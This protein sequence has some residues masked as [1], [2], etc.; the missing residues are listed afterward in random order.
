MNRRKFVQTLG[1][2]APLAT[3]SKD[4]SAFDSD[5]LRKPIVVS[6]WSGNTKANEK[7]WEQL[8]SGKSALDSVHQGVMVPE[9]DPE[10]MSVGL[11][12]LPDRDGIVTL[13][14]CIMDHAG[15]I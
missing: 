5:P 8:Q 2:L 15:N 1:A 4:L 10:D 13:D 11:G 3:L 9:A 7:A 6:T 14:A 12:G